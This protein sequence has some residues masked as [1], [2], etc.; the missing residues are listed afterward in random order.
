MQ[1]WTYYKLLDIK[2][3]GTIVRTMGRKQEIYDSAKKVWV[4][5]GIMLEYFSDESDTYDMYEEIDEKDVP[6][7]A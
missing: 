6:F 7:V 2:H 3:Q 4:R 1:E 5:T